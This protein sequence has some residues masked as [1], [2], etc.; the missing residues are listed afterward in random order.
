M[1]NIL[2]G[3]NKFTKINL[4]KDTLSLNFAVKQVKRVDK[5]LKKLV[6]S[7]STVKKSRNS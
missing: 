7:N 4:K 6:R 3:Q 1:E 2:S 5:V